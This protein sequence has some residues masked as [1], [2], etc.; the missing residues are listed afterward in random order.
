[1]H[2]HDEVIFIL[3]LKNKRMMKATVEGEPISANK[4]MILIWYDTVFN[5]HVKSHCAGIEQIILQ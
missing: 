5:N 1:M 2:Y 4:A 3:D